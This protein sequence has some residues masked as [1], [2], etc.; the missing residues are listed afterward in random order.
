M[1]IARNDASS[2]CTQKLWTAPPRDADRIA[3]ADGH[4]LA[5]DGPRRHALEA[6]DRFL[7]GVVAV[8]ERDAGARADV[9]ALDG[10]RAVGLLGHDG[11]VTVIG[12]SWMGLC[13][14]VGMYAFRDGKVA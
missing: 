13:V 14:A 3:R 2:S 12:P 1:A 9:A 7:E 11:E 4:G 6:V 10:D 8:G 5:V